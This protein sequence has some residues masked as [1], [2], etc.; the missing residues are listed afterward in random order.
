MCPFNKGKRGPFLFCGRGGVFFLGCVMVFSGCLGPIARGPRSKTSNASR[1]PEGATEGIGKT[2]SHDSFNGSHQTQHFIP[3]LSTF[4]V[5]SPYGPRGRKFHTGVDLIESARG[6]DPIFASWKGVVETV[7]HRGGYG[8][9]VLLRHGEMGYTRYAHLQ[10]VTVR[11]GQTIQQGQ[12][13]GFVGKSGR[14]TGPHLHFEIL[15]PKYK[16]VDP[17]PY[18][19]P[20]HHDTPLARSRLSTAQ[21]P[22]TSFPPALPSPQ[23]LK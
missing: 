9:M 1:P 14:A 7:S 19:F 15:T 6:G 2:V 5:R 3:P 11:K 8:R 4:R 22:V 12:T 20:V 10:K 17:T 23:K 18:L 13:I 16:T 21:F